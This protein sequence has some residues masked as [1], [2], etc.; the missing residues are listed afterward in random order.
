MDFDYKKTYEKLSNVELLKI[1]LQPVVYRADAIDIANQVLNTREVAE[2]EKE[3]AELFVRQEAAKKHF[4]DYMRKETQATIAEKVQDIIDPRKNITGEIKPVLWVR[5]LVLVYI[6]QYLF[7]LP[8]YTRNLGWAIEEAGLFD[9]FTIISL[10]SIIY[11]P[12][13]CFLM[14]K[15]KKW[16]WR[17]FVFNAVFILLMA[18]V[19][20]IQSL[21]LATKYSFI[22]T[23]EINY[24]SHL[25]SIFLYGFAMFFLLNPVITTHFS[26]D[27]KAKKMTVI[28]SIILSVVILGSL[29]ISSLGYVFND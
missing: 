4:A 21:W 1:I 7:N 6:I 9:T 5:L 29:Y 8:D 10:A 27:V 26:I 25:F 15:R 22:S 28:Y 17:L 2:Q 14:L 13:F 12:V 11:T 20:L 16:G 3:Q 24:W 18:P 23:G 19:S